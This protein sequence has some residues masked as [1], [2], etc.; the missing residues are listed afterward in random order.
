MTKAELLALRAGK[1][2]MT[3][4]VAASLIDALLA[5]YETAEDERPAEDHQHPFGVLAYKTAKRT[6][7]ATV[8]SMPLPIAEVA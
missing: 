2:P 8:M 1:I 3:K 7:V 6:I 4:R 5:V